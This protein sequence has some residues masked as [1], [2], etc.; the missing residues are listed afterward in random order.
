M[1][2]ILPLLMVLVLLLMSACG[3]ANGPSAVDT[4]TDLTEGPSDSDDVSGTASSGDEPAP[5]RSISHVIIVGVDGGGAY[6]RDAETPNL[7]RIMENGTVTYDCLTSKPTISAQCW[8]SMLHGVTPAYHGLSN[9]IVE[10]TAYPS[11]SPYPSVFRVISEN[12]PDAVMA[13]FCN[14]DPINIGIIEDGLGITKDTAGDAELTDKICGY[15]EENEPTLLFIQYDEV[16]GAGHSQGYGSDHHLDQIRITDGYIQR[17]Y[18]TLEKRGLL[19][20]TLL[21]VT[22]DH[23]G[24]GRSHG[25]W[26][27]TERYVMFAAAGPG[28]EAGETGE[29]EVRDIASIVLYAL[30]LED[31]QPETW[32]SRVPSHVFEGVEAGER[33]VCPFNYDIEHRTHESSPTPA[34]ED[35]AASLLGNDRVLAYL[36]LDGNVDDAT[37]RNETTGNGKLY[38]V[39]GYFGGAVQFDDGYVSLPDQAFGA[40][41]YSAAFWMKTDG[42]ASEPSIFSN[43]DRSDGQNNGFVF[44]LDDDGEL[45][46]D[47]CYSGMRSSISWPLP[48]DYPNGWVYVVFVMDREAKEVRISYDFGEFVSYKIPGIL[49]T[50]SFDAL[51]VFNIGQDGT[52]EHDASLSAVLDEILIVDGILTDSD[53]ETL[54]TLYTG[55]GTES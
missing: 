47:M 44:S 29:M 9:G 46:F 14:W 17:I 7:D 53:I 52:G 24:N 43:K 48:S 55:E 54:R 35:S 21:I 41:S 19:D 26:S 27:I 22:A 10:E 18:E 32:T 16:D 37:G 25:G 40:N 2:R 4:S 42:V 1:K 38:Y 50:K 51:P 45:N 33:P 36:P 12:M 39:E 49:G 3:T 11:D 15:L 28:V 6:F 13:S 8:G 34:Y 5:E 20:S 31:K 30:G 23:G